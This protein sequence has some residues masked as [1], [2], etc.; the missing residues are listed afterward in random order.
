[1]ACARLP[2]SILPMKALDASSDVAK[3]QTAYSITINVLLGAA[4][5]SLFGLCTGR[6]HLSF[7]YLLMTCCSKLLP[8]VTGSASSCLV[9]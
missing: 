3:D 8:E 7:G 6:V 9:S 1:M 2:G 5:S 4:P